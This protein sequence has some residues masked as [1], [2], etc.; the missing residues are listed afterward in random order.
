M[1]RKKIYRVV[2]M[3]DKIIYIEKI[4]LLNLSLKI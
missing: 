4:F 3:K 2:F 1:V